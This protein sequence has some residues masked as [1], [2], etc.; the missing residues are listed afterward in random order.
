MI[1]GAIIGYLAVA[2]ILY[3]LAA[4]VIVETGNI[5]VLLRFGRFV[6]I[7]HPGLRWRIPF[8]DKAEHHST[9][10]RQNEL[11]DEPERIDRLNDIAQPGMRHPFRVLHAGRE[12]AV[13]Y[14]PREDNTDPASDP[15]IKAEE[16]LSHYD[17]KRYSEIGDETRKAIEDDSLHSPL[18]G[19]IAVSVEWFLGSTRDE[20]ENFIRN[21]R[22]EAGRTSREAEVV[23]RMED[24]IAR[25]LQEILGPVTL[26][27]ARERMQ[28]FSKLIERRLE[29]LVEEEG[30]VK[31]GPNARPWGIHI[32]DAYIKSIHP[33]RRVNEA[34]AD[35]AAS[36][37]H[38]YESIRNF[39]AE[40]EQVRLNAE[41]RA[42]E[43]EQQGIGRAAHL[44]AVLETMKDPNAQFVM[45]IDTARDIL[46]HSKLVIMPSDLGALGGILSLGATIAQ[47]TQKKETEP[48]KKEE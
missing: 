30:K 6:E 16:L 18:T 23:K 47:E 2:T 31:L 4:A 35:A 20:V 11:P 22:P 26:G 44:R 41:A 36:V 46:P 13:Y 19:E 39:E 27:H 3:I 5:A 28:L 37:S 8:I 43:D 38:K 34:R 24:M 33:G 14:I 25:S 15:S 29:E 7:L 12:E 32:R 10:T 45:S 40:A 48:G 17:M 21:V 1:I 9:Q 42:Y